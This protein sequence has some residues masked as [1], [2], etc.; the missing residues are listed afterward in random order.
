L[1]NDN[2]KH[3]RRRIAL[4][5]GALFLVGSG[6]IIIILPMTDAAFAAIIGTAAAA[7]PSSTPAECV[8]GQ[9]GEMRMVTVTEMP[10]WVQ[11]TPDFVR[12]FLESNY[13]N[14]MCGSEKTKS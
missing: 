12:Y 4:T 14:N 9:A 6:I 5:A 8:T 2:N 1:S 13:Y 7:A 10:G 3:R 11:S